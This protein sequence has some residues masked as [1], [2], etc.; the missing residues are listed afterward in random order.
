MTARS[1]SWTTPDIPAE[2]GWAYTPSSY[3]IALN[4]AASL[5]A[6]EGI[7]KKGVGKADVG[8]RFWPWTVYM[9]EKQSSQDMVGYG[10]PFLLY[11]RSGDPAHAAGV[12]QEFWKKLYRGGKSDF[13]PWP[14]V[15]A[16]VV[17][18]RMDDED[19]RSLMK[20]A[21][22]PKRANLF[23]YGGHR[24]DPWIWHTMEEDMSIRI[25][26]HLK[27]RGPVF[28]GVLF[29]DPHPALGGLG[30]ERDTDIILP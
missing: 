19:Y 18:E 27:Q 22:A 20:E 23:R 7:I 10:R 1:V 5:Q 25:L 29:A 6:V 16:T 11:A 12:A 15:D 4:T 14:D 9:I 30:E 17:V 26:E 2:T 24:T 3:K 13:D 21:L 28:G 8:R